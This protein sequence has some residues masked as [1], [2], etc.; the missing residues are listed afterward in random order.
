MSLQDLRETGDFPDDPRW[1]LVQRIGAS[2]AFRKS[3]RLR[4]LLFYITEQEIHGHAHELTEQQ[5]GDRLFHK[6]SDY[7]PV[8]DSSV[9]VHARQL[10]LKLHEYFDEEG[11]NESMFVTIPRGSY[12]PAFRSAP[13]P[14]PLPDPVSPPV[15]PRP[16]WRATAIASLG[17]CILLALSCAILS[18]RL[19]RHNA[20]VVAVTSHDPPWPYSQLFDSRHQTLLVVAD[21]NYGMYRIVTRQSGS[22]DLYLRR[23]S[24][25]SATMPKHGLADLRLDEYISNSTLTSFADV[26]DVT[27]LVSMAGSLSR[28]VS[29]RYPR[30]LGMRDLDHQNYIFIGSPASNPWVSLFQNKLNFREAENVVGSDEKA[31]VNSSPLPGEPTRYEGLGET[32]TAGEDYATIALLPNVT[33]DGS[34][35]ILQGL[36]QEGTEAAGRFL[37]DPENR[38]ELRT[39][40]GLSPST[41]ANGEEVWF[42]ALISS[43]TTAGA[44]NSAR[45]VAIRRIRQ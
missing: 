23:R 41:S 27:S 3:A 16:P 6:P 25:L 45:L 17:L 2:A 28:Q 14:T 31:F 36:Q 19:A 29:V 9:R 39:A 35:L 43:R 33:H 15:A 5:I 26:A 24:Q 30:E 7:S 34:V 8:E 37:T 12:A 42:E 32:G 18:V 10:R 1:Q 22:L 44:S 40:L 21:S 13:K 4:E 11:R 38:R 20:A